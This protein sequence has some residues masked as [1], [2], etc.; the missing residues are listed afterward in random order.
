MTDRLI[1]ILLLAGFGLSGVAALVA[2]V[3]VLAG[4][5]LGVRWFWGG[6]LTAYLGPVCF[7]GALALHNR[8]SASLLPVE[9]A[10]EI[11]A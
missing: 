6:V 3:V 7:A 8:G 5:L 10:G 4:F 1:R 2:S 9:K 11:N